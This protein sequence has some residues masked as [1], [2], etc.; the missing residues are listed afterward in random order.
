MSCPDCEKIKDPAY[1][2]WRTANISVYGC[3]S[4][5][6]EVFNALREAQ[7]SSVHIADPFPMGDYADRP[8]H[9]LKGSKPAAP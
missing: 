4:H 9:R 8:I 7:R 5:L 1:Y 2:R 3:D 6:R